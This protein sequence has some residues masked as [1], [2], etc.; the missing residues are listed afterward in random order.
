MES[1]NFAL[2]TSE[3]HLTIGFPVLLGLLYLGHSPKQRNWIY[4]TR[5]H[6]PYI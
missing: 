3:S 4:K 1:F 6:R 5:S 2:V